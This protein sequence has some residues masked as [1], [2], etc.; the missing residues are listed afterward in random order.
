MTAHSL[1]TP[2]FYLTAPAPCPYIEG[3]MERK[4]FTHL[5]GERAPASHEDLSQGG[6][7]R[8]QNIAY[9]PACE[10]CRACIA[11][12]V[13]VDEF[14]PTKSMKRIAKRNSDL[15]GVEMPNA[16]TSEQYSLFRRYIESRHGDGGMSSMSVLDYA[17]MVEDSHV[18]TGVIE[19]RKRGPD[20]AFT[21]TGTGNLI[22][23]VLFDRLSN[24]L[25]MVYSF[26]EPSDDRRSLGTFVILDH[27]AKA[28]REGLSHCHLGYWVKD[29]TKMAYKARFLPQERL[30]PGGWRRIDV[31]QARAQSTTDG[32]S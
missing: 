5:V 2:Q 6:F 3:K 13:L 28:R 1:N 25:S 10:G 9:R 23:V 24:G 15:I 22:A 21:N 18:D 26:F 8:S 27:I 16:P 32:N 4:V 12:R 31:D 29:S 7:R 19:Y 17:M 11:T 20:S 14:S 30:S